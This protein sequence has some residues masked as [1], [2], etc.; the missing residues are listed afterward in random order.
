MK[1]SCPFLTSLTLA[2]LLVSLQAS[3]RS[4]VMTP[5]PNQNQLPVVGV[6]HIFQDSEGFFWYGTDGGGLCR[7]D[8]YTVHV[9]RADVNTPQLL[10][11]NT[12]TCITEDSRHRIW[13]GTTR[14]AYILDKRTNQIVSLPDEAI[15]SWEIMAIET[16]ST[17]QVWVAAGEQLFRY[18]VDD[19]RLGAYDLRWMGYSKEAFSLYVDRGGK[20]WVALK[21]G[22]LQYFDPLT[23]SL[24]DMYWPFS[25]Y[26]TCLL[27]D[28]RDGIYWV[29]TWGKG[30]LKMVQNS[31]DG[32][33]TYETQDATSLQVGREQRKIMAMALDPGR[34]FLWVVSKE[35]VHGYVRSDEGR[36]VAHSLEQVLPP[37]IKAMQDIMV[38]RLGQV[39]VAGSHP[40]S[41]VLTYLDRDFSPVPMEG[42]TAT[43]GKMPVVLNLIKESGHYWIRVQTNGLYVMESATGKVSFCKDHHLSPFIEKRRKGPGVLMV[44]ADTV[45]L[46]LT[47]ANGQFEMQPLVTLPAEPY[48]RIRTFYVDQ[49]GT[50]W[51]GSSFHL[52]RFYPRTGRLCRVW[53]GTGIINDIAGSNDG[54]VYVA[55]ETQ[56]LLIRKADGTRLK[57]LPGVHVSKLAVGGN[58]RLWAATLHGALYLYQPAAGR[59]IAQTKTAGLQGDLISDLEV[60]GKGDVWVVTD[61]RLI[62]YNPEKA[63]FRVIHVS[64]PAVELRQFRSVYWDGSGMVYVSGAGG[65][66]VNSSRTPLPQLNQPV[67]IRLTAVKVD[68]HQELVGMGPAMVRLKP[69]E[70]NLELFFSTF[71]PLSRQKVRFAFR[72]EGA[73]TAWS[74]LDAGRNSLY[75]SNLKRGEHRLEVMATDNQGAWSHEVLDI[76]IHKQPAWYETWWAYLIYFFVIVALLLEVIRR[77]QRDQKEKQRRIVDERVAAMKDQFFT[78][79]SHEL[80][81]PL[82]LVI[83]PL[84]SLIRQVNDATVKPKLEAIS[85]QAQH[86]LTLV[87]QL[88]DFRKLDSGGEQLTLSKGTMRDYL[89]SVVARFELAA[90]EKAI[91]LRYE[92]VDDPFT[93]VADF[94][95]VGK[96]VFNLLSNAL[97]FT[98]SGGTVTVGVS[99]EQSS[100][101]CYIHIEVADTGRGI[102]A[103][104][105]ETIFERFHQVT[106]DDATIGTGIGLHLV[107]T[108][109][110]LLGGRITVDS[111]E[112]KGSTFH[113]YLPVGPEDQWTGKDVTVDHTVEKRDNEVPVE[114]VTVVDEETKV[115]TDDVDNNADKQCIMLVEDNESFRHYLKTELSAYYR[116]LEAVDGLAGERMA[117]QQRPDLI[118]SDL[119]MPGIDGIELCHRLKTNLRVSHIP[120]I[121]L[122]A[123]TS[124]EQ[125]RRGYMEGADA[126]IAKPFDWDVLLYRVRH[127]LNQ[128]KTRIQAFKQT[129]DV[130]PV[131]LAITAL[132]E[133]F[134]NKVVALV[135]KNMTNTQYTIEALSSDMAMSRVSLYRKVVSVTGMTPVEF[136][137]LLRLKEGAR[138]LAEG[139]YTV[140]EVADMV[141]FNSP[142]YFTKA[143]KKAFGKLPTKL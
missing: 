132:D 143:F 15:K 28:T 109:A 41:F 72:F 57:S 93:V 117:L 37:G 88:L 8:G 111:E 106:G 14:G 47:Y 29:G 136:V 46:Q 115:F 50:I 129:L 73:N 2:L 139:K 118:I 127:L 21:N 135:E 65:V 138:L 68:G 121:L 116:V 51:L 35:D 78:N 71:S 58:G 101:G 83:T 38:D 110:I 74:Y 105:R 16:D 11:S 17:G 61:Q 131:Q 45:L 10:A 142:G 108:Y 63:L 20:V 84:Q 86:V 53:V 66:L 76:T 40:T 112:G 120:F 56:G 75:L 95:K 85:A 34:S 69:K 79:I 123:N 13:F 49:D 82:T 128:Q 48:E 5:L 94:D 7:D 114:N 91:T 3:P 122:T 81:T 102:P 126:Y 87:N 33:W 104:E 124:S 44:R 54:T 92:S 89:A 23:D 4:F 113:L 119:M 125:E 9:F 99:M 70:T 36:L 77:Y 98:P 12:V 31:H 27:Q 130:P 67:H 140:S 137:R 134:L 39:W 62:R 59:L 64:D 43:L 60:D 19:Q 26:P 96:M 18:G 6:N 141:G 22:G 30:I 25:E 1:K 42:L 133:T 55:T 100:E 52:Y 90:A 24:V 107:K 103:S 80:R 97:K 32:T